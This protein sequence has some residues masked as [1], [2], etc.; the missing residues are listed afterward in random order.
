MVGGRRLAALLCG[1]GLLTSCSG[2]EEEPPPEGT[3]VFAAAM[4]RADKYDDVYA[5]DVRTGKRRNLTRTP[6]RY[7]AF[8]S[9]SPDRTRIAFYATAPNELNVLDLRTGT[10]TRLAS[11]ADLVYDSF[12]ARP[13]WSPDGSRIAFGV[14][15]GCDPFEECGRAE[16]WVVDTEGGR[17]LRLSRDG[18]VASW[19]P[20]G[21]RLAWWDNVGL[22]G[23]GSRAIVWDADTGRR[24]IVG[25]SESPP[26][27]LGEE[28][29]V[30]GARVLDLVSGRSRRTRP[31]DRGSRSADGSHV[32]FYDEAFTGV[33]Y[34]RRVG[35]GTFRFRA[36]LAHAWSPAGRRLAI[37]EPSPGEQGPG[38][39]LSIVNADGSGRRALGRDH[40]DF[41]RSG[42]LIWATRN[43]LV[44]GGHL[45]LQDTE[46][47]AVAPDGGR[48]EQLTRND[49][50]EFEPVASPDGARIAFVRDG[51]YYDRQIWLMRRD[52]SAAQQLA[53][54]PELRAFSPAW[55][56]DGDRLAFVRTNT[57]GWNDEG[58][59]PDMFVMRRD[60]SSLRRLTRNAW[61][62]DPA[63]SAIGE[64]AYTRTEP[65]CRAI[66]LTVPGAKEW[67]L[68]DCDFYAAAPAWSP[69]G[70]ELAFLGRPEAEVGLDSFLHLYVI[71]GDGGDP[72]LVARDVQKQ[73]GSGMANDEPSYEA[74]SWSPDGQRLVYSRNGGPAGRRS[75]GLYVIDVDEGR[76][77][78]IARRGRDP[79]WAVLP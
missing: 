13:S 69:D 65:D 19:S 35:G 40:R 21:R 70:K 8:P 36:V 79:F 20:D 12:Q 34:V 54:E 75:L 50:S 55:S 38:A 78:R 18:R 42:P 57:R 4:G 2:S 66:W 25:R 37:L 31:V 39:L 56:P 27:W 60:G 63:W 59:P 33:F 47:L 72:R 10:R 32:A 76:P 9:V 22:E 67:R 7:E 62:T 44:Y 14:T 74:P 46:L 45:P 48:R 6:R 5:V 24:R 68:T 30:T 73:Q 77:V 58:S 17:P 28:M 29:L 26:V 52:G 3:V 11:G 64:L 23:V 15:T 16:I 49:I 1:V 53:G 61:V 41:Q 51:G 43:L 71:D